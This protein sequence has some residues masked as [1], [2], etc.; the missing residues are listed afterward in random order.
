VCC[1]LAFMA[2]GEPELCISSPFGQLR[3]IS[4]TMTGGAVVSRTR[5]LRH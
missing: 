1:K 4:P 2:A 5:N 3:H